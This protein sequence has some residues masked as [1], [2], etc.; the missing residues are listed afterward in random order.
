MFLTISWG[1]LVHCLLNSLLWYM[2]ENRRRQR[3]LKNRLLTK[4]WRT[5]L[6]RQRRLVIWDLKWHHPEFL[7]C[8]QLY[9]QGTQDKRLQQH[10]QT[11]LPRKKNQ[12]IQKRKLEIWR[13]AFF[14][15]MKLLAKERVYQKWNEKGRIKTNCFFVI[16]SKKLAS[17]FTNVYFDNLPTFCFAS[18]IL[19]TNLLFRRTVQGISGKEFL[20]SEVVQFFF[21]DRSN[22][23]RTGELA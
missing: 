16:S 15:S 9:L 8:L 1:F 5:V 17:N 4:L 22:Q 11:M 18:T 13:P 23:K 3:S 2:L 20:Q 21:E 7:S 6:Q 10:F 19:S 12:I 14:N